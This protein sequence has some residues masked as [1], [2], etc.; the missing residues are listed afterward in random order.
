MLQRRQAEDS[1]GSPGE[2][3]TPDPNAAGHGTEESSISTLTVIL[4]A[5][6]VCVIC[7]VRESLFWSLF[8]VH[9]ERQFDNNKHFLILL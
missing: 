1:G 3:A 7:V 9:V 6:F 2:A 5:V 4:I 8:V